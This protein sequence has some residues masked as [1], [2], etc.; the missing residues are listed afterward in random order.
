MV[1]YTGAVYAKSGMTVEGTFGRKT[2]VHEVD[3]TENAAE[4]PWREPAPARKPRGGM[5]H[6]RRRY[7]YASVPR[8][9]VSPGGRI[10]STP[11]DAVGRPDLAPGIMI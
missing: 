2:L 5:L 8:S 9:R 10:E 4:S 11:S 7:A 1:L 6:H 3:W